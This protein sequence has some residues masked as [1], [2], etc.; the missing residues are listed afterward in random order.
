M[1]G[2]VDS[3]VAAAVLKSQGHEVIG[4]TMQVWPSD[5]TGAERFQSCCGIDAISDARAVARQLGIPHYVVNFRE[6]FAREVIA[7]FCREYARGRTPNPCIRCNQ[8]IK[9]GTLLERAKGLG[10]DFL[11]TG[12][13]AR[14]EES[15]DGYLLRKGVD[16]SK[17]QSYVL[18]TMT[19][20]QLARTLMPLGSLT[21]NRV[22]QIAYELGLSVA[23]KSES[24][25][26]CFVTDNDYSRFLAETLTSASEPGP[27][28]DRRGN[29]LG[30]HRGIVNY[31]IGQRRGLGI[32]APEPLY[33]T[34]LD[35]ERNAV[36]VGPK[37][38]TFRDELL[39]ADINWI[40]PKPDGPVTVEAKIRYKHKEARA[41][42]TPLDGDS[43]A[44]KFEEPQ[45]AITPGQAVVFY[46]DDL[47][48][49]GGI[50]ER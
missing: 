26:I 39:A 20:E 6:V 43:A 4:I 49:G 50:I 24:Q 15:G 31:T 18:H 10:A 37:S 25:E 36:I 17:D 2:G 27:V 13:Y 9:F 46:R 35:L 32:A 22:R 12:H 30:K 11:A 3:S 45:M 33:V 7:D 8:H 1:S 14:I 29:V 48:L 28:I 42:V 16:T 41:L 40:A 38:E 5:E 19:P 34:A 47:V 21:K 44:V 23:A